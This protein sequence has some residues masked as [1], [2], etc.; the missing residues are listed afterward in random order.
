VKIVHVIASLGHGGAEVLLTALLP[1]LKERGVEV[2]AVSANGEMPLRGR[3]EAAGV[4]VYSLRHEGAVYSLRGM[5]RSYR[6]LTDVL[7]HE[8]PDLVHSHLYLPDV[9]S[10]FA[11]PRSCALVTTL[12]S[13]D[14]WWTE[15][16]RVRSIGKTWL[17]GVT[18]RLR[19]VHYVSVSED[20]RKEACL[21]LGVP[22]KTNRVIYNGIDT[23]AFP[24]VQ[25]FR[26]KQIT[27]MQIGRFLPE[28][29]HA[30]ALSALALLRR[31]FPDVRLVL[32]GDGP[33]RAALE[34]QVRELRLADA[35]LF[36]G[37]R[38]DISS[39]LGAADIF[40]MP[41]EWEGLGMACLEAMASGLP[42]IATAVGG[43]QEAVSDGETGFLVPR[44]DFR[45][46]A[47]RTALLVHDGE[48][49]R[50]LGMNGRRKVEKLFSIET[51]A[52]RYLESY[53]DILSGRW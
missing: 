45:E 10:R 33:L 2:V 29:G 22:P 3:L 11:A 4:E 31:S 43:L 47:A 27:I 16:T 28:K 41:S 39:Q 51:T 21:A 24:L 23:G 25:R 48:L 12:H 18:G 19:D 36:A 15:R 13:K 7:N 49:S 52:A 40:W 44:G 50:R 38:E 46:L 8:R 9:L 5:L 37:I 20:V 42:V 53:Q 35:V 14:K 17:D 34:S 32:V 6:M 26:G 1:H 30:T